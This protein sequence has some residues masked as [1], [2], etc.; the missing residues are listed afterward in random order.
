MKSVQTDYAHLMLMLEKHVKKA[1]DH[2]LKK[3]WKSAE[4]NILVADSYCA[5]LLQWLDSQEEGQDS[6][7]I[8]V[9]VG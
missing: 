5:A 6:K 3:E 7:F 4:D 2:C 8:E 9:K 1:H